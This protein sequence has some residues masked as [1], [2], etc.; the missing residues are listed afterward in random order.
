V[1]V[2]ERWY[3]LCVCVGMGEEEEGGERQGG[4]VNYLGKYE[5]C[6]AGV[7]HT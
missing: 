6:N 2:S 4:E 3:C 5:R 7:S 1:S